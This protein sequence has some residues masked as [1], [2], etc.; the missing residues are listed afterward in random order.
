M[1]REPSFGAAD[2]RV[3]SRSTLWQGYFRL[4]AITLQHRRFAGDDS[5]PVQRL[6]FERGDAVAVL[7][8]DPETD[9]LLLVEQLR[10]GALRPGQSP[11]LLELIAGVVEPGEDDVGVVRRE[12]AEEAGA[13]L[14]ELVPIACY[15]PS[16]GA[17]SE[18][19]R[20]FCAR[21]LTARDGQLGG[22]ASE[23]EDIRVHLVS[24]ESALAALQDGWVTSSHTVIALQWL[25]L[26]GA[27]LRKHW[28]DEIR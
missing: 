13:E 19:L 27:S 16:P 7:P 12:A 3:L 6:L 28:L 9:Q 26:H 5:E 2:C 10:A 25:A 18:Q 8:W 23:A 20:V 15:Y 14:G 24:R 11:W 22:L 1:P 21:L 4:D 17:C